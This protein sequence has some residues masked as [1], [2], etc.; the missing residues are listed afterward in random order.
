M[1]AVLALLSDNEFHSG[2]ELGAALGVTRAAVWKKLKKLE[3]IGVTVHSVKGRGYRLPVPVE[4]LSEDLLRENG[5]PN[6]VAIKLAFETES[7]NG[8]AKQ[9]IS[10]GKP[11]PVLISVERQTQGTSW[12]SMGIRCR[13]KPDIFVCVAL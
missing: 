8:D 3:S 6:D 4:L 12:P 11:L 7:T 2:E 13:K 10:Q 9:Y 5:V 1:Q